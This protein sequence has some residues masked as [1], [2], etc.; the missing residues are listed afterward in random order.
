MPYKSA[1]CSVVLD[2]ETTGLSPSRGDRVIEVGAVAIEDG[3]IISEFDTLIY[4]EKK[5]PWHAQRVHGIT[6]AML[7]GKPPSEEVFPELHQFISGSAIIA[8]NAR[9]DIGFLKHE[10]HCIGVPFNP[11]YHCTLEM[12]RRLFPKLTNHK[13]ET[14]YRHLCGDLPHNINGHRALDDARLAARVWMEMVK[15]YGSNG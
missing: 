2:V 5:I 9:F 13:L 15:E 8:H 4:I 3:E 14:V 7:L 11:E 6:D 10:F 1:K 12:S